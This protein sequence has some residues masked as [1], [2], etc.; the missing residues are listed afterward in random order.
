[1]DFIFEEDM[2]EV[3]SDIEAYCPKCKADTA[4]TVIT[5]YEDEVRRVQCSTCG[6]VHAYRK[7]RGEVEDD[8]PE[9]VAAKKRAAA[10]KP[11]WQEWID[12]VG[13]NKANNLSRPYTIREH[14]HE[15]DV[16]SHPKFGLGVVT[17]ISENKA[18]VT[19]QDERRVLVHNRPDLAAQMP[20]IAPAPVPRAE[21]GGKGK[22]A[23]AAAKA[24]EKEK[25]APAKGAVAEVPKGKAAPASKDK[26]APAAASKP[27]L[28]KA[29]PAPPPA[30]KRP[31]ASAPP[32]QGKAARAQAAVKKKEVAKGKTAAPPAKPVAAS[33]KPV[34]AAAK[35]VAAPA[36][37]KAAARA[38]AAKTAARVRR[39]EPAAKSKVKARR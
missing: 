10:K 24:A 19:F 8:V 29:E 21:K 23:A 28:K 7:P 14:Y 25:P 35:A 12:K 13:M 30:S 15:G 11:S 36:K 20:A 33:A 22:K 3:G 26:A 9:P 27:P 6:D 34:A 39:P 1:M 16:V 18:E 4:H 2:D 37:A 32:V 38:P 5:K 31:A 17:E